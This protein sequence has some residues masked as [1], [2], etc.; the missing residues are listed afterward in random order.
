MPYDPKEM[1]KQQ[2]V[3]METDA[4]LG[5]FSM[6]CVTSQQWYYGANSKSKCSK[7]LVIYI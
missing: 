5:A 7:S 2:L 4:D 3:N 6:P 1:A